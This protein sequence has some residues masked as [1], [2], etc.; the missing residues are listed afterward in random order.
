M[1]TEPFRL[2][3]PASD[4]L[5]WTLHHT[6]VLVTF[7]VLQ[8]ATFEQLYYSAGM[9]ELELKRVL[10]DLIRDKFVL[11]ARDRYYR[12]RNTCCI[13]RRAST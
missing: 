5:H 3:N 9:D 1:A 4:R 11:C 6:L 7:D 12:P 8:S 13:V 10:S 2:I